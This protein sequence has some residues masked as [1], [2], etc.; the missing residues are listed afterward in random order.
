MRKAI[1]TRSRFEI[2]KRDGFTC[3]YCGNHPPHVT[4]HIDHINPVSN[5]GENDE[6][7]LITSCQECNLG[8]SDKLLTAI[9]KNLKDKSEEIAERE[10]QIKGYASIIQSKKDRIEEEVW[11]VA[12]AINKRYAES[13]DRKRFASIKRFIER[14]DFRSALEA[15]EIASNKFPAYRRRAFKYFCGICWNRIKE[16]ENA[17]N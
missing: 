1:S 13:I 3:Q 2:F 15:A 5:G 7:N 14:L 4:L 8:K 6:D 11:Q 10:K 9:P 16:R 12:A 17:K